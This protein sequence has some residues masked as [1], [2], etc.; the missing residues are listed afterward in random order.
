M[1]DIVDLENDEE[2]HSHNP[3]EGLSSSPEVQFVGS[4]TRRQPLPSRRLD[5][6]SMLPTFPPLIPRRRTDDTSIF[7]PLFSVHRL[8][9]RNILPGS[10]PQEESMF[11]GSDFGPAGGFDE[12]DHLNYAM[13]SFSMGSSSHQEPP[14]R[15]DA[16]KPP[17]PAPEG[18]TRTLGDD[19]VAVC[20][21]CYW[22]LG[23]GEGKRQE[24]WVAKKCGHVC[25]PRIPQPSFVLTYFSRSIVE[26]ALR[27]DPS[28]RLRKHK[29]LR[30]R[31]H[32]RNV[33]LSTAARLSVH[34]LQWFISI[35]ESLSRCSA[36][37]LHIGGVFPVTM[38]QISFHSLSLSSI[39]NLHG[40]GW[41]SVFL[42]FLLY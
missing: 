25:W 3:T 8:F 27:I 13:P 11:I 10:G 23:T 18:F 16:Y 30:R 41:R 19:D 42:F 38:F 5:S 34:R 37:L 40:N 28:Q 39:P 1:E 17:S 32:S 20:P 4:T 6:I 29:A 33:R 2:E 12:L 36:S 9:G 21:N 15:R 22:E 7:P 26:N 31:H 35:F 14:S 24:I